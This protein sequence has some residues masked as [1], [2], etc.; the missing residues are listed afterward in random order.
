[1]A[2]KSLVKAKAAIEKALEEARADA[3]FGVYES[4]PA[5]LF[6]KKLYALTKYVRNRY[7]AIGG[8]S[9]GEKAYLKLAGVKPFVDLMNEV[10][11]G[12]PDAVDEKFDKATSQVTMENL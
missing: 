11:S 12:Y 1:M 4:K 10:F 8:A 9:D 2:S 6:H 3:A 7:E 5:C